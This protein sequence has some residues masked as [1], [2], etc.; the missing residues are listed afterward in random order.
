[1]DDLILAHKFSA[2]HQE[3]LKCDSICG[4]FDCL[5]IFHPNE[6]EHWVADLL[7]TALCPYCN[8]DTVIGSSSG[9]P[10][11]ATFLKAMH[12]YWCDDNG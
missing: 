7:G 3:Q 11:T 5:A 1:M 10:I 9:Y 4:C 2:N 8:I 6:I 12:E